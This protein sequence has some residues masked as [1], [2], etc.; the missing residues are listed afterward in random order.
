MTDIYSISLMDILPES[1]KRDPQ[2]KA[3]AEAITPE[4]Q[5]VSAEIVNCILFPRIDNLPVEIV[6][7]LAWQMHVDWYDATADISVKRQLIKSASRIHRYRGTPAAVEEIIQTYFGDG[8]L[9]E[10][11]DYGGEPYRFRVVTSNSSVTAE[12]A[13]QFLMVLNTVKNTRSHLDGILI[14]LSGELDF[15]FSGIVHTVDSIEIRQVV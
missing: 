5:L 13:D 2:I 6:D 3:L 8:Y 14:A 9:E 10:W 15:F 7:M 12:L 1:L 4:I 11:F